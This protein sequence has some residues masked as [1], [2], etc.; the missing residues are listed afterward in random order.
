VKACPFKTTGTGAS[1]RVFRLDYRTFGVDPAEG[2]AKVLRIYARGPNGQEQ[3]LEYQGNSL[4]D[5]AQ[6]QG[7]ST[8]EWAHDND[9]WSGK[10]EGEEREERE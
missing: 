3:M 4:I 1:G 10:W 6:F 9:R 2:H 5:G 7:W 8:G